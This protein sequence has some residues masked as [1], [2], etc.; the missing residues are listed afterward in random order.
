MANTLKNSGL[1]VTTSYQ[2]AYTCPASTQA[3]LHNVNIANKDVQQVVISIRVFDSSLSQNRIIVED[4]PVSPGGA[5]VYPKV[6]NL[7][8]SDRIEIVAD[9]NN[10]AEAF[11]S[12]VE[13]T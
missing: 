3:A 13:I 7:E 1:E 2:S 8:P 9:A 12:I 5:F 4:L 10:R 6:I 11:I